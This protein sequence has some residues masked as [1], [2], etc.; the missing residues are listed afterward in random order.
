MISSLVNSLLSHLGYKISHLYLPDDPIFLQIMHDVK[1]LTMTSPD[2]MYALYSAVK[3][4]TTANIDGDIVECGVWKG[5]SMLLCA[6]TISK[7]N[8]VPRNLYL[9][10]TFRG[11]SEPDNVDVSLKSAQA[12]LKYWKKKKNINYNSWC[13]ATLEEVKK[14]FSRTEYPQE[15]L[16][17][18]KGKVEDTIP[19]D[20]PSKI[21]LLRLDTD[22]YTSTYHELKYLYPKLVKGG[23][24]IIDDYRAWKGSKEAVDKYFTERNIKMLLLGID[25]SAVIGIKS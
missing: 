1:K 21:A 17:F 15:L 4:L 9:Y 13:Y 16:H 12:A 5:G 10:D 24:L 22:W 2:N 23:V 7:Y 18:I 25:S 11:M 14:V 3:Y 20:V 19:A 8:F 6:K